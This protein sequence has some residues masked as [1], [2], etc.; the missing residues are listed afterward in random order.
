MI[1]VNLTYGLG[2]NLFQYA[3]GR[4]LALKHNTELLFDLS[5]Q[6]R[7]RQQYLLDYLSHFN[8]VGCVAKKSEI[9]KIKL[10]NRFSFLNP[11]YKNSVFYEDFYEDGLGFD[12]KVLNASENA[13]IHGYWQSEKYFKA[14]EAT[15][16]RDFTFK[17]SEGGS[18]Y[19]EILN[20]INNSNSVSIHVRRGDYL[21]NK[22]LRIFTICTPDYY[23]KAESLISEKIPSPKLFIFSDDIEWVKTNMP[24][25]HPTVFV[26]DGSLRDYQELMLMAACKHNII[27]NSTFSWWGAWLN[28]NPGKMVITPKKWFVTPDMDEKDL[29]PPTWIKI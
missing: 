25:H 28:N 17:N 18:K 29:I 22:N 16:R 7:G 4:N 19:E 21:W 9:A 23:Y 8:T 13:Y 12:P 3:L 27:A 14:S 5:E 20:E 1:I 2:N 6:N 10:L 11:N 24:F 26:T 15:L